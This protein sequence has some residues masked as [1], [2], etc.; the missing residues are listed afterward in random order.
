LRIEAIDLLTL[1]LSCRYV[2][3][4]GEALVAIDELEDEA[5]MEFIPPEATSDVAET[6]TSTEPLEASATDTQAG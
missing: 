4:L 6:D 5:D 1:G 3:T 2:E